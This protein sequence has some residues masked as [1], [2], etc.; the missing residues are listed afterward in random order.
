M[1]NLK[2]HQKNFTAVNTVYADKYIEPALNR[3]QI[4]WIFIQFWYGKAFLM[5]MIFIQA[6]HRK[7]ATV[8]EQ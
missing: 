4:S 1:G 2:L 5:K 7:W 6:S 8:H 3:I